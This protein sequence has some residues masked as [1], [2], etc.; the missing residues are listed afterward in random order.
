MAEESQATPAVVTPPVETPPETPPSLYVDDSV[1]GEQSTP[2]PEPPPDPKLAKG[3]DEINRRDAELVKQQQAIAAQR[4]ELESYSKAAELAKEDP[5][6]AME[7][8]GIDTHSALAELWGKDLLP[9]QKE[10]DPQEQV[11]GK[12]TALEKQIADQREKMDKMEVTAMQ[13]K[14]FAEI[15]GEIAKNREKL[16][17]VS[18]DAAQGGDA[19]L[20]QVL[21]Y[22]LDWRTK[23]NAE[24]VFS[25]LLQEINEARQKSYVQHVTGLLSIEEIKKA[26]EGAATTG[27]ASDPTISATNDPPSITLT[28]ELNQGA[29]KVDIESLPLEQR[30]EEILKILDRAYKDGEEKT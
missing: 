4:K 16:P 12:V 21:D 23:N 29:P 25:E 10:I 7:A 15:S 11:A 3:W 20:Q 1:P 30:R 14:F 18:F 24:P 13:S 6:K 9:E 26:V 22:A 27:V 2:P 17:V 8:M 5:L 28:N 19:Y